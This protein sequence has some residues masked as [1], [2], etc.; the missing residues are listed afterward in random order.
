MSPPSLPAITTPH[1]WALRAS[2][3]TIDE[4]ANAWRR[5]H[6]SAVAAQGQVDHAAR[7]VLSAEAWRG[8][9]AEAYDTHRAKLGADTTHAAQAAG[10]VARALTEIA[11]ALRVNQAALVEERAGL[12]AVPVIEDGE[13][14]T[15]LPRDSCQAQHVHDAVAA[16]L[17]YRARVDEVLAVQGAVFAVAQKDLAEISERWKPRTVRVFDLNAFQGGVGNKMWPADDARKGVDAGDIDELGQLILSNDADVVTLQETF[18][19]DMEELEKWLE[20][21]T[22]EEWDLHFST[23]SHKPHLGDGIGDGPDL[24][25]DF[26]NT[27]LVRRGDVIASSTELPEVPLRENDEKDDVEGRSM[28]GASIDLAG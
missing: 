20:K 6:D 12:A 18:K 14:L 17:G 21:T 25:D 4:L 9:A 26:G 7:N 3:N 2:P 1:L 24:S 23:A 19:G 10:E 22:G 8:D 16:A 13:S 28:E 5:L 27:V 15:F 11:E